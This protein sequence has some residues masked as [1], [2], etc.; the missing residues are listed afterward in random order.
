M[1]L[2]GLSSILRAATPLWDGMAV[3]DL[4]CFIEVTFP[5]KPFFLRNLI[6]NVQVGMGGKAL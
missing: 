2:C 3:A 1:A 5:I 6:L 4:L